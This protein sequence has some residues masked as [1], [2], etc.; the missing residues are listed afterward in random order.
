MSHADIMRMLQKRADYG[1]VYGGGYIGGCGDME[2]SGYIG[3]FKGE[4]AFGKKFYPD[5]DLRKA[6]IAEYLNA[7]G[8]EVDKLEYYTRMDKARARMAKG[9]P[10]NLAIKKF[11]ADVKAY[12]SQFPGMKYA[13]A[14]AIVSDLRPRTAKK[15]SRA[16]P[17]V[18]RARPGKELCEDMNPAL[19]GYCLW[20][21]DFADEFYAR[22]GIRPSRDETGLAWAQHKQ[23]S[24]QKLNAKQKAMLRVMVA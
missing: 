8:R 4:R 10:A 19:R 3:G 14:R 15:Y 18:H 7:E 13:E 22:N 20:R 2:G 16:G 5:K 9:G 6:A 17:P 12:K 11:N 21:A 23:N 24:G 1:D